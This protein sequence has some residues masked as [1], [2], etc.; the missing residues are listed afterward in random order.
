MKNRV[1]LKIITVMIFFLIAYAICELTP[2]YIPK[3]KYA[4]DEIRVVMNDAEITKQLPD[5]AIVIGGRVL[6]SLDT[7]HKYIDKYAHFDER[8]NTLIFSNNVS[9][10]KMPI[11]NCDILINGKTVTVEVPA[12]VIHDDIYVP[13]QDIVQ[14]YGKSIVYN[15]KVIIT[16]DDAKYYSIMADN[17]IHIKGY[18]KEFC[19]TTDIVEKGEVLEVFDEFEQKSDDDY[20]WVRSSDGSLGYVKKS[21]IKVKEVLSK[22][23]LVLDENNDNQMI[24]LVWEYAENYTPNRSAEQKIDGLDIVAPTW[25]YVKNVNGDIKS[26]IN[27]SYISWARGVG[28]EIWPTIKNDLIEKNGSDTRLDSTSK[29]LNDMHNRQNFI[30]NLV[31]IVSQYNFSGI[32]MDF[33]NMYETDKEEYAE[34]IRELAVTLRNRGI[35]TS[36]C[37]NVPDGSPTWSLCFDSKAISDAADYIMVMT[38]D[39][40]TLD[41][42]GREIPGPVAGLD[43]VELNLKKMIERDGIE[44]EKLFL[45]VPFY[46]RFWRERNGTIKNKSSIYMEGAKKYMNNNSQNVEWLEDEGQYYVEYK[47]G[48]DT[49]KIWVEDE[50]SLR[51]K[52]KLVDKYNLAGVAAWRRGQETSEVWEVIEEAR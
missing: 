3:I 29:L 43:W 12:Q 31:E 45:G 18:K 16:D 51:E 52:L 33:E 49:I 13:I 30:D 8:Y 42:S 10:V 20:L 23:T 4:E 7:I 22:P 36:V 46:S 9:L 14:I 47:D 44:S 11:D 21:N 38:Y 1:I 27:E 40:Y 26:T 37:V 6:M 25:L 5:E 39:Q 2:Y 15:K 48:N 28:Y 50:N 35:I 19:I 17:K 24:S 34:L 41:D 32:N